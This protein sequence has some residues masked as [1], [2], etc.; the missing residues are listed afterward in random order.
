M[1]I[2]VQ[3]FASLGRYAPEG[4][5]AASFETHLEPGAPVAEL[6]GRLGVPRDVVKL[7]F[8]NGVHATEQ[9]VLQEG[10]RVGVFPPVAGG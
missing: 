5:G 9:T 6:L 2:E 10:D 7:V 3:L 8:V 1:K 4:D